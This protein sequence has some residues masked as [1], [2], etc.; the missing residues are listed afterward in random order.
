M[1]TRLPHRKE[2]SSPPYF[3]AHFALA[4]SPILTTA[5][6]CDSWPSCSYT[7]FDV[8]Q[9]GFYEGELMNG[10]RGLV[11]SNFIEKVSGKIQRCSLPRS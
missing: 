1:G 5:E 8:L 4:R 2:Y 7:V 9:D 11:P 6:L 3:L 10:K